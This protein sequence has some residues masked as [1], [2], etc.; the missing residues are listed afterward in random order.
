[1]LTKRTII[2]LVVGSAIIA[3]GGY[4]L[5]TSIGLQ[6]VNVNETFGVG[7]STSYQISA[8]DGASQHMKITGEK[9]NLKL[10]SPGVGL[11]IP[12]DGDS[13]V[14]HEKEVT[15]DWVHLEDGV[16]RIQLQNLGSTD[17]IVE[18]KLNVT[19]DPILFSYHFIVIISGMIII[20]FSM[21]FTIRKPKGF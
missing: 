20:G 8:S 13:F 18:A 1:M 10:S 21:G 17:M 6:T 16:T 3:V 2:G 5:I 12:K 7:E 11:Q 9:F 4:S 19:T 15:L 14:T